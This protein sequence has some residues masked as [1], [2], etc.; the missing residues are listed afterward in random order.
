MAEYYRRSS[1]LS[2]TDG[3]AEMNPYRI[4]GDRDSYSQ[5]REGWTDAVNMVDAQIE[6]AEPDV[7][8]IFCKDCARHNIAIGDFR[9]EGDKRHWFWKNE[10]CPMIE[11][12]G[13]AQGHEFDYQFCSMAKRKEEKDDN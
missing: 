10:A 8:I 5:Y 4:P 13:K 2:L 11:Y 9:E 1:I 12:R 6:A 3:V 7:E